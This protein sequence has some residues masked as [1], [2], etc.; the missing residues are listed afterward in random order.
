MDFD[1]SFTQ[2]FSAGLV[3]FSVIDILGSVPIIS[4]LEEKKGPIDALKAT[5]ASAFIMVLFL[6]FGEQLLGLFGVDVQSFGIAGSIV[7]FIIGMELVLDKDIFRPVPDNS[8]SS[9][10]P[11]AFPLI[12]GPGVMTI[13]LSLKAEYSYFNLILAILGNLLIIFGILKLSKKI[14]RLIGPSGMSI[15]RKI[16]GIILLAMAIK[17]F[18]NNL[19]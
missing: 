6:S 8:T 18:K 12:A 17:L 7:M 3:L 1:L 14:N 11:V 16:F 13:L 10:V 5:I 19:L 15:F 2:I 9:I 4:N